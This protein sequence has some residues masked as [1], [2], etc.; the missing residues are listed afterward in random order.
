MKSAGQ[1]AASHVPGALP[2][3]LGAAYFWFCALQI[4]IAE[5]YARLEGCVTS[6]DP[7][8]WFSF[9]DLDYTLFVPALLIAPVCFFIRFRQRAKPAGRSSA[10]SLLA[11]MS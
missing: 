10:V 7:A 4:V 8:A 5:N 11:C 6:G 3:F 1:S 2:C 9:P